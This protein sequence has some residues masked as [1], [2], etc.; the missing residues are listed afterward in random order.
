[1]P[2][3]ADDGGSNLAIAGSVSPHVPM[4]Y[5]SAGTTN[6]LYSRSQR[7]WDTQ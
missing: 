7:S 1:M 5:V 2:V 6:T 3:S 4:L